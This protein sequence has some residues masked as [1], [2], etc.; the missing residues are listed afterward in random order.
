MARV[1]FEL[2]L[3]VSLVCVGVGAAKLLVPTAETG[4]PSWFLHA[5]VAVVELAVGVA[6]WRGFSL[7]PSIVIM[8]IA[9]FGLVDSV[10]AD[11]S[12]GCLGGLLELSPVQHAVASGLFG[13]MGTWL[14]VESLPADRA[15]AASST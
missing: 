12:C 2:R 8:A 11:A 6:V 4:S 14:F 3:L 10:V 15:R 9:A 5:A 13:L 7:I 1:R